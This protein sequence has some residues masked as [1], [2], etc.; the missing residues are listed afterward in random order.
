MRSA[1]RSLITLTLCLSAF[2]GCYAL[3]PSEDLTSYEAKRLIQKFNRDQVVTPWSTIQS[4]EIT[5]TE[6][7]F[8][9]PF[10]EGGPEGEPRFG[11]VEVRYEDLGEF[12]TRP[13]WN[14][15]ISPLVG[16]LIGPTSRVVHHEGGNIPQSFE[17]TEEAFFR[18]TISLS[19]VPLWVV[20][21]T[22]WADFEAQ[23]YFEALLLLK[24]KALAKQS[25]GR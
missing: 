3:G 24:A 25:P 19:C 17:L 4:S 1:L 7:S 18:S 23:R 22:Y 9:H 10:L 12:H 6:E 2:C 21:T 16:F 13:A 8:T 11:L 14:N 5:A 15:L 20:G